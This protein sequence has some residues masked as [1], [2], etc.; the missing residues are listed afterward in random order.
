MR[1]KWKIGLVASAVV[2][3][4]GGGTIVS[5]TRDA[6]WL[7]G[8]LVDS[9]QARTGR[10]VH[11]GR[12][13][14]WLLPF[15][16]VEARDVRLAGV[17]GADM[18]VVRQVRARLSLTPLFAHRMVFRSVS[19]MGATLRLQRL[20]D[21]RADWD[22][23]PEATAGSTSVAAGPGRLHWNLGLAD[24]TLSQGELR[25]DDQFAH[26]TGSVDLPHARLTGLDGT[27]PDVNIQGVKNQARFELTGQT[28]PLLPLAQTLPLQLR[29]SLNAGGRSL[30]LAHLD[31][32]LH[33]GQAEGALSLHAGGSV[34]HLEDLGLFFPHAGLPAARNVSLDLTLGGVWR[35]PQL[36]G[37]HG[38]AEDITLPD[39]PAGLVLQRLGVDAAGADT[40]LSFKLE[41]QLAGQATV[42]SGTWGNAPI[43]GRALLAQDTAPLPLDVTLAQGEAHVHAVGQAGA[44]ASELDVDGALDH[45]TLP[46]NWPGLTGFTVKGHV[47]A[48]E[49][50]HLLAQSDWNARL[51]ALTASADMQAASVVWQGLTWTGAALHGS[52]QGGQLTLD[53]VSAQADGRAQSGR[54]VYTASATG[55]QFSVEAHPVLLPLSAVQGW[56]GWPPDMQGVAQFVGAVSAGGATQAALWQSLV[57]HVGISVVDGAVRANVLKTLLGPNVPA[58]GTLPVRCFGA[59]LQFAD[60]AAHIDQLGLESDFLHVRGHGTVTLAT[61]ALD[62]HLEPH[63]L[64]GGAAASSSVRLRGTWVAPALS[65]ETAEDGR[66]GITIGGGAEDGGETCQPLLAAAREGEDGPAAPPLKPRKEDKVMKLLHGLGLFQ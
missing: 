12:L 22:F 63:V 18:L 53:P 57:G 43:V 30:G 3:A 20:P 9:V 35:E 23:Q 56:L 31:G 47:A 6:G 55:P 46:P 36:L 4:V 16:W 44:G 58:K 64:L 50:A 7:R 11:I 49:T 25:W 1:L 60:G 14:V 61:G 42:L 45:L 21:G 34:G 28:G 5:A 40:P 10:Q 27:A 24:V 15:P 19:V 33:P 2:L 8:R 48:A 32:V 17:D 39:S 38:R 54:F 26:H 62:M 41:G 52:V 66:Y 65:M 59:H 29:L 13:N 51:S 37:L